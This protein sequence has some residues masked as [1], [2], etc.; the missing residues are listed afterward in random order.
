MPQEEQQENRRGTIPLNLQ[1]PA[2]SRTNRSAPLSA[3][4]GR[5]VS[6]KVAVA[7]SGCAEKKQHVLLFLLVLFL[8]GKKAIHECRGTLPVGL[9]HNISVAERNILL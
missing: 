4:V 2:M 1:P 9:G 8:K 5:A 6:H 7:P 3:A